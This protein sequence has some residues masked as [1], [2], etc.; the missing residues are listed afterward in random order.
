MPGNLTNTSVT[1]LH[2]D[3]YAMT[4]VNLCFRCG[5]VGLP[6]FSSILVTFPASH[7]L[8]GS[9]LGEV[10]PG[11]L[12]ALRVSAHDNTLN[13]SSSQGNSLDPYSSL[14]I[15]IKDIQ[16]YFAGWTEYYTIRT[17]SPRGAVVMEQDLLVPPNMIQPAPLQVHTM[18][19]SSVLT[20]AH[21]SLRLDLTLRAG[22]NFKGTDGGR[23]VIDLPAGF[24]TVGNPRVQIAGGN[25]EGSFQVIST[26]AAGYPTKH[27]ELPALPC[28]FDDWLVCGSAVVA[29]LQDAHEWPSGTRLALTIFGLR[30]RPFDGPSGKF[31][32]VMLDSENRVS[33]LNSSLQLYLLPNTLKQTSIAPSSFLTGETVA[34]A[35]SFSIVNRLPSNCLFEVILPAAYA[36]SDTLTASSTLIDGAFDAFL[37]SRNILKNSDLTVIINRTDGRE[38]E[39]GSAVALTLSGL[40]SRVT[41]GQTGTFVI[42]TKT[43]YGRTIDQNT[44]IDGHHLQYA[45]PVLRQTR[46]SNG[47]RAGLLNVTFFG[48]QFGPVRINRNL[49]GPREQRHASISS[50]ACDQTIWTSDSSL[51]CSISFSSAFGSAIITIER[52]TATLSKSFSS[53]KPVLSQI[54]NMSDTLCAVNGK[55]FG[56]LDRSPMLLAGFTSASTT[57]WMS[58]TNVWC[59]SIVTSRGSISV[60]MTLGQAVGTLTDAV[61]FD[62]LGLLSLG[63]ANAN[64]RSW[65]VSQASNILSHMT[66]TS[67]MT[68]GASACE[69]TY[70]S[71]DTEVYCKVAAGVGRSMRVILTSGSHTVASVTEA[72]SFDQNAPLSVS[73]LNHDGML[74]LTW[75][76][77]GDVRA[78]HSSI[79]VRIGH[80]SAES[81]IWASDSAVQGRVAAGLR[82]SMSMLITIAQTVASATE[83][84]SYPSLGIQRADTANTAEKRGGATLLV[85]SFPAVLLQQP[86]LGMRVGNSACESMEWASETAVICKTAHG[87]GTSLRLILT[88]GAG[89]ATLSSAVSFDSYVAL[90]S[91]TNGMS[92]Q[93]HDLLI[94]VLRVRANSFSSTFRIG[95]SD[96]EQTSWVSASS[97]ISHA[98]TG[99]SSC[100]S[101][102]MTAGQAVGSLSSAI[103]LDVPFAS[104]DTSSDASSNFVL[105]S[106][107]TLSYIG[108]NF[109]YSS[110]S[111]TGDAGSTGCEKTLWV[112]DSSLQCAAMTDFRSSL[113]I[114]I[115]CGQ[116]PGSASNALTYDMTRSSLRR[117]FKTSK[118]QHEPLMSLE[119]MKTTWRHISSSNR[120]QATACEATYWSSDTEV[121]CKVAAGVGRSMRVILTSGSHTVAS[122]TEAFSF[123]QNAPLSVSPLNHDGMLQLTWHGNGDVRA[124]HSSIGVRIGHSSAESS[125]WASDS[126]VQGRVA[127][128][129]RQSMSML[130]TIAQTVASATEAI[131]YPSLGIQRADTANTAEKRGGATLLVS[132]FPAVLLQQPCLG[133][134]VGNSACESMEW[135]SETAVIC[136]TAHGA[137]T[138]LRLILTSGAGA[139]TLSSAVSYDFELHVSGSRSQ[140]VG[141]VASA[142]HLFIASVAQHSISA[143]TAFSSCESTEWVT[144]TSIVCKLPAGRAETRAWVITSGIIMRSGSRAI[145]FDAP[146]VS[147][148]TQ[149]NLQTGARD[150]SIFLHNTG[151]TSQR[152]SLQPRVSPSACES[153]I[154]LSGTSVLARKSAGTGK[155]LGISLTVGCAVGSLTE[156][157][158]VDH[159]SLGFVRKFDGASDSNLM[160]IEGS[161]FGNV[162]MT[163]YGRIGLTQCLSSVWKSDSSVVCKYAT[164]LNSLLLPI[165]L[166]VDG[167]GGEI[168]GAF[169]ADSPLL[170]GLSPSNLASDVTALLRIQGKY[171][172]NSDLSPV[173]R[174]AGTHCLSSEWISDSSIMAQRAGGLS[175]SS[176][177]SLTI[178]TGYVSSSTKILSFDMPSRRSSSLVNVR[179]A[180]NVLVTV[181]GRN[182]GSHNP[183]SD[184]Q[185]GHTACEASSWSSDST[186]ACKVP[187]GVQ[188][189]FQH[190]ITIFGVDSSSSNGMSY[191]IVSVR[192]VAVP[193]LAPSPKLD[194]AI[195]SGSNFG[196]HSTSMLARVSHSACT[197]TSWYSETSLSCKPSSGVGD[198]LSAVITLMGEKASASSLFSYDAAYATRI[199]TAT[200]LPS[201]VGNDMDA[202]G[203]L[204]HRD[205]F[206][207]GSNVMSALPYSAQVRMGKTA[208]E[209]SIWRSVS[210]IAGK[211]AAGFGALP[212]VVTLGLQSGSTSHLLSYD[213]PSVAKASPPNIGT[214]QF[215]TVTLSGQDFGLS[216]LTQAGRLSC[217]AA[218]V[219][220]WM[221]VSSLHL[222]ASPGMSSHPDIPIVLTIQPSAT[223]S[224]SNLFT[225]DA[226]KILDVWDSGSA[227]TDAREI[228]LHGRNFGSAA[229]S[230]FAVVGTYGC[231]ATRWISDTSLRCKLNEPFVAGD[232]TLAAVED[233]Q[234]CRMCGQGETLL[235]CTR[236]NSGFCVPCSSCP[237]GYYRDCFAGLSSSGTCKACANE[238][239]EVGQRYF[240]DTEGEATTQCS[241]CSV[242][243]GSN[244]DGSQN[245]LNRCTKETDTVCQDCPACPIGEVRVGCA[246]IFVGFCTVVAKGVSRI[247]ATASALLVAEQISDREYLTKL[248]M[249]IDLTGKFNGNGLEVAAETLATFAGDVNNVSIT[250]IIPS[251][252]MVEA[253]KERK[254][255]EGYSNEGKWSMTMLSPVLYLSPSGMTF[256]PGASLFFRVPANVKDKNWAVYKWNDPKAMWMKVDANSSLNQ[257]HI[258]LKTTSFS[259]YVVMAPTPADPDESGSVSALDRSSL[260]LII[261]LACLFLICIAM[262]TWMCW[263]RNVFIE[264]DSPQQKPLRESAAGKSDMHMLQVISGPL[265]DQSLP[266]QYSSDHGLKIQESQVDEGIRFVL[267]TP[268]GNVDL[269]FDGTEGDTQYLT[270]FR[271]DERLSRSQVGSPHPASLGALS[272][273]ILKS[274]AGDIELM[275][276]RSTDNKHFSADMKTVYLTPSKL[277][278]SKP[279]HELSAV[280]DTRADSHREPV[281]GP[282]SAYPLREKG[283]SNPGADGSDARSRRSDISPAVHRIGPSN[284]HGPV[285]SLVSPELGFSVQRSTPARAYILPM[286]QRARKSNSQNLMRDISVPGILQTPAK[287][288][289]QNVKGTASGAIL[290]RSTT[291]EAK[292]RD[293]D[294][295]HVE[296]KTSLSD[297]R[298]SPDLS[299]PL[300]YCNPGIFSPPAQA[301]RQLTA[302]SN[303]QRTVMPTSSRRNADERLT[304]MERA[305][306][307]LST[308]FADAQSQAPEER[309]KTRDAALSANPPNEMNH[310]VYT[311]LTGSQDSTMSSPL[312]SPVSSDDD[313]EKTLGG[314][315]MEWRS[316]PSP[317]PRGRSPPPKRSPI[318]EMRQRVKE[319][320]S[321]AVSKWNRKSP[322]QVMRAPDAASRMSVN[323][324][325]MQPPITPARHSFTDGADME[326]PPEHTMRFVMPPDILRP[327][328]PSSPLRS[329]PTHGYGRRPHKTAS[330]TKRQPHQSPASSP[331]FAYEARDD[332]A[333]PSAR[334]GP[335]IFTSTFDDFSAPQL[336][337]ARRVDADNATPQALEAPGPSRPRQRRTE[338][339]EDS[340]GDLSHA[341]MQAKRHHR[342]SPEL[343]ATGFSDYQPV[344]RQSQVRW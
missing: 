117:M 228:T 152:Y 263:K 43:T 146:E 323:L 123:D 6:S 103:S 153:T 34:L 209:A 180:G 15:V 23:L 64:V 229:Y 142:I 302:A 280:H 141:M 98:T 131:S 13:I 339:L 295:V 133:M 127:A 169:S 330:S 225:Y 181:H 207:A 232:V 140:N 110:L 244:Q 334:H 284:I 333:L 5:A 71:S 53:D 157:F 76:G 78:Q 189:P 312:M 200:N 50:S 63:R 113:S 179:R 36:I 24:E 95:F 196:A 61:T 235:G 68:I 329:S 210:S 161:R 32:I 177:L 336:P 226:P 215:S 202:F 138:S 297:I 281:P 286:A 75:H 31:R 154:W 21:M 319:R 324:E 254:L 223:C 304:E 341:R 208:C 314:E 193:N 163:G 94:S 102:V 257:D 274:R 137:G 91:M 160:N 74:Q 104:T 126:A 171:F 139:A 327:T 29:E 38:V 158:T 322:P 283:T 289:A 60:K 221:S 136:K 203:T 315:D 20:G 190:V 175:L 107:R 73:P 275:P 65:I 168:S 205:S 49:P 337:L 266:D 92:A 173:A 253:Q 96:C 214:V 99:S 298:A 326:Q 252:S 269:N 97:V 143:R 18:E 124:Q 270:P 317:Q 287:E 294:G 234:I 93:T 195:F 86:C 191:D 46:A 28:P 288:I 164:L 40:V 35:M 9:V 338:D 80:S 213:S 115:T 10:S 264:A 262:C 325:P 182:L 79:G 170:F 159:P 132:S 198:L 176:D 47:P 109:G 301:R 77:N 120:I 255:V 39:R 44:S 144:S 167:V 67:H 342:W 268:V 51:V 81:S 147:C 11:S 201:R 118:A 114:T 343:V 216:S 108:G 19:A 2:H 105:Y 187:S 259:S 88:S 245:E 87:A 282:D 233:S 7:I 285:A 54:S 247:Q 236:E 57:T 45:P 313:R 265:P 311:V 219:S 217:S 12:G 192:H 278:I 291:L 106:P 248:P 258:T 130:I 242:C 305:L 70:W 331:N 58:D 231:S 66:L 273:F 243:G 151:G 8:T 134:R 335:R 271:S 246:G 145:S 240:K 129:L 165:G 194:S 332:Y 237:K 292:D 121:Y 211:S 279:V 212:V 48:S 149:G 227:E 188:R 30:N 27:Y 310:T 55:N 112:S 296:E 250:A 316:M 185:I 320:A 308:A 26:D 290:H 249:R 267:E 111:S 260:I 156:A 218:E 238:D 122:V 162:D 25:V 84:I 83:A 62:T 100:R 41:S 128:G 178:Q 261:V 328:S 4:D 69:A 306:E 276:S 119:P 172:G 42:A 125:I 3:A 340:S 150:V 148:I 300:L 14:C 241:L 183:T 344:A 82:Q 184:Q 303:L 135:A 321:E 22:F 239:E 56:M 230:L 17:M 116:S 16:N 90:L 52:Q 33:S 272:K 199:L 101:L 222:R 166:V 277:P 256:A 155:T 251:Q 1:L 307:L 206:I 309:A 186:L 224:T 299:V 59:S 293:L 85:S 197:S 174:M 220:L 89:A 72:F 318:S 204:A 37:G